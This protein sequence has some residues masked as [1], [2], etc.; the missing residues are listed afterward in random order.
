MLSDQLTPVLPICTL[1]K[2]PIVKDEC[3]SKLTSFTVEITATIPIHKRNVKMP[4]LLMA[5]LFNILF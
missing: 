2:Y 3:F 4:I 5:C 1:Y